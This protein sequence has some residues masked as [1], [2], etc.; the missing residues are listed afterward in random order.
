M[1]EGNENLDSIEVN[2][3]GGE[4][5][6]SDQCGEK[7]EERVPEEAKADEKPIAS[8]DLFTYDLISFLP[9]VPVILSLGFLIWLLYDAFMF[10]SLHGE[11]FSVLWCFLWIP[12]ALFLS[13]TAI[14]TVTT[15]KMMVFKDGLSWQCMWFGSPI[16]H[17]FSYD[18]LEI[19]K[20]K[21]LGGYSFRNKNTKIVKYVNNL[22][23]AELLKIIRKNVP[24]DVWKMINP[25]PVGNAAE[26]VKLQNNKKEEF[27]RD[28][29]R[30]DTWITAKKWKD[31]HFTGF[32]HYSTL[33]VT[34]LIMIYF[35]IVVPGEI[36][37]LFS[38]GIGGSF[39]AFLVIL[40]TFVLLPISFIVILIIALGEKVTVTLKGNFIE[41]KNWSLGNDALVKKVREDLEVIFDGQAVEW[42]EKTNDRNTLVDFM[43]DGHE[44]KMIKVLSKLFREEYWKSFAFNPELTFILPSK[45]IG[46]FY[47]YRFETKRHW[48][49]LGKLSNS[50][51]N[52]SEEE[53]CNVSSQIETWIKQIGDE[54][55]EK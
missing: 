24:E 13:Y 40:T 8:I 26:N 48:I 12:L 51:I 34:G 16:E 10:Y 33:V 50:K 41:M 43:D 42:I 9:M 1:K 4:V 28:P 23:T 36:P 27:I 53:Y 14:A 5:E 37:S 6:H 2:L 30:S 32:A 39:I 45:G 7:F 52:P 55:Q 15:K 38:S 22:Y 31:I 46:G 18:S 21:M 35:A 11:G 25:C 17:G 47:Y 54:T 49:F 19:K 3:E 44:L 20:I 29:Y